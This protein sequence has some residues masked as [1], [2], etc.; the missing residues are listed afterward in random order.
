[1]R[2]RQYLA[3]LVFPSLSL[4][5]EC[6][7]LACSQSPPIIAGIFTMLDMQETISSPQIVTRAWKIYKR[8]GMLLIEL[9]SWHSWTPD[10]RCW[11][12]GRASARLSS[13]LADTACWD[14]KDRYSI[15]GRE[16]PPCKLQHAYCV[17]STAV[18]GIWRDFK[19]RIGSAAWCQ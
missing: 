5:L 1:M 10:A 15:F 17:K 14:E 13:L 7:L 9:V 8:L 19:D 11:G 16:D 18:I 4:V 12:P 3:L 6:R 2:I